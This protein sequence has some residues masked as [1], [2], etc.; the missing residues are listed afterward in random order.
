MKEYIEREAVEKFIEDGLNNPDKK[1]AFGHD[2]I[3]IMAEVHYMPAAD[4]KPVM[5]AEWIKRSFVS[6][7]VFCSECRT[8]E[9]NTDSNYRSRYCPHC[10]AKMNSE[11]NIVLYTKEEIEKAKMIRFLFPSAYELCKCEGRGIA[12]CQKDK[13]IA[14]IDDDSFFPSL[15]KGKSDTLENIIKEDK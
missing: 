5:R 13:R 7:D 10:G 8:I 2:A 4:V 14:L 11:E 15:P 3:E 1:K 6:S 12:I 9:K